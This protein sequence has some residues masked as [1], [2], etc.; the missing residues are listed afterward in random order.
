MTIFLFAF[1]LYRRKLERCTWGPYDP[2]T[3]RILDCLDFLIEKL[4][5]KHG[6]GR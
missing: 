6:K 4:Q 3:S 2:D 5:G 1:R